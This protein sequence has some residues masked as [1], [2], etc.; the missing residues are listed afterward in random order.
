MKPNIFNI[1]INTYNMY[2]HIYTH[3]KLRKM[4]IL[5]G[6]KY[7]ISMLINSPVIH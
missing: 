3:T 1:E 6:F 2:T 7:A 4:I 5:Q